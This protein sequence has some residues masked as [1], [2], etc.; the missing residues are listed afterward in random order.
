[1]KRHRTDERGG[2]LASFGNCVKTKKPIKVLA[3]SE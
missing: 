2:E 3:K 1:V